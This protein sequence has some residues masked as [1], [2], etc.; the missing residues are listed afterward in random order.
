MRVFMPSP[1]GQPCITFAWG[2][3]RG[4][5]RYMVVYEQAL[6]HGAISRRWLA[7]PEY[8]TGMVEQWSTIHPCD[9]TLEEDNMMVRLYFNR[10]SDYTVWALTWAQWVEQTITAG[11]N[12]KQYEWLKYKIVDVR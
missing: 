4:A 6:G 3:V 1:P 10:P 12:P 9:Y 8:I 5:L 2:N 11:A 7:A